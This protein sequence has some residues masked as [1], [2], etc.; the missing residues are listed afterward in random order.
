MSNWQQYETQPILELNN[1]ELN[2]R[3][4]VVHFDLDTFFVS[5]ERL[6]NSSLTGKPVIV[7]GVSDRSVV[8]GCSYEA[9]RFWRTFGHAH[10]TRPQPMSG[11]H[12]NSWRHGAIHKILTYGYRNYCRECTYIRKSLY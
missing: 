6:L 3:R 12:C 7:G 9:R 4:T 10:E 5:V 2:D 1:D 11:C 8:A